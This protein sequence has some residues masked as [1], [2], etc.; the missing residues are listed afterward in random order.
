MA[1]ITTFP[2]GGIDWTA[3]MVGQALAALVLRDRAGN[4]RSGVFP[5]T[6]T[7]ISGRSDRAVNVAPFLAAFNDSGALLVGGTDAIEQVTL[8]A[9]PTSGGRIDRICW[10]PVGLP[11]Y[12]AS[13]VASGAPLAPA[14]PSGMLSLGTVRVTAGDPNTSAAIIRDDYPFTATAGGVLLVRNAAELDDWDGSDSSNAYA[15]DTRE[16]YMRIAGAWE[17]NVGIKQSG[18][19]TWDTGKVSVFFSD[20]KFGGGEARLRFYIRRLSGSWA[21]N[22]LI[23]SIPLE[24]A[25]PYNSFGEVTVLPVGPKGSLVVRANGQVSIYPT[26]GTGTELQG[27]VTW[28]YE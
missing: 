12:V 24:I 25:P 23:G 26:A 14:I 13:G 11:L 9:P 22:D 19:V 6:E 20:L 7:L 4:V 21:S 18:A 17:R 8:D 5:G 2:Q 16:G 10:N 28:S 3:D 15:L 1:E 27:V